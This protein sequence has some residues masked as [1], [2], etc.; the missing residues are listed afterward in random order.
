MGCARCH[1]H[2]FDPI[3]QDDYYA[4]AGIFKSTRT[5]EHFTKIARWW[6]NPIPTE[7]DLARKSA[8]DEQVANQKKAIDAFIQRANDQLKSR[9][10]S[11][12]A[13]LPDKPE[14]HYPAE[15][16]A[17][18]KKLRDALAALEKSPP[19]MPSAIGVTEGSVTDVGTSYSWQ[20]PDARS[21]RGARFFQQSWPAKTS[22]VWNP[23][24][25]VCN[26]PAG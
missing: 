11:G 16:K 22:R 24:A 9:S 23:A 25:A 18:L 14:E 13:P 15:T 17:E 2:K 8:H 4:M 10:E 6:E 3:R 1:D 19:E 26:W 21:P 7:A 20:P 5:M 12:S